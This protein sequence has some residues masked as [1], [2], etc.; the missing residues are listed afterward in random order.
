[1]MVTKLCREV[2]ENMSDILEGVAREALFDHLAG[3]ERCRDARH[4]AEQS[5][6][7]VRD[8]ALDYRFPVGL[9]ARLLASLPEEQEQTPERAEA[10]HEQAEAEHEQAE[11]EQTQSP[12]VALLARPE[13]SDAGLAVAL[14]RALPGA[15][16]Q[17]RGVSKG[18]ELPASRRA[19]LRSSP[20]RAAALAALTVLIVVVLR[21]VWFH[22][23]EG[24]PPRGND[25]WQGQVLALQRAFGSPSGLS[26]CT[27][28]GAC[29]PLAEGQEI[30]AGARLETDGLTRALLK[31]ADGST[32]ALDRATRLDLTASGQR[33]ARLVQGN[34]VAEIRERAEPAGTASAVIDT[35][36][37]RAEVQGTKFSLLADR[38]QA[39]VEVSRGVVRLIDAQERS[40]SV[41][42]GEAGQIAGPSE[43][44]LESALDL[45]RS[46]A[47]SSSAFEPSDP[48]GSSG[49]L[50]SLSAKRPSD[51]QELS[52]AV[53]LTEHDVKVQIV[54][55]IAR[56]E[57]EEVFSN[58]TD[59]VLEGI[60]RFPLPPGAQ[61]ERLALDVDGKLVD[62]AYVDRERAAAIWRGAIVNAGGKKA[63]AE[64]IIWVPGPW[65]DPALLEWQRGNRFELRIYPIPRR[66]SRRVLI[67]YTER[68]ASTEGHRQYVYPL[69]QD[70]AAS[71]RIERFTLDVQVRGHD[72]ARGVQA[73]GYALKTLSAAPG[74]ARLA[75]A[76][77]SFAPSGDLVLDYQLANAAAPLRAWA[78]Q[79]PGEQPYV[80]LLLR[81]ELPRRAEYQPRDYVLV[82]DSSRS[83]IGENYRRALAVVERTIREM[84]RNDR[85]S[86]LACDSECQSW[87]GGYQTP[88]DAAADVAGRFLRGIEPEGAS[89][90]AFAVER[91][92]ALGERNSSRAL[93]LVYLGDGTPTVGPIHPAL[94]RHAVNDVLPRGASLSAVAI[95]SDADRSSLQ[96]LTE[97]AGGVTVAFSPG[98]SAEDVAY[99]LL[100][101]SYGHTLKNARLTLPE[102]LVAVA[103]ERLGSIAAGAEELVV[104]RLTRPMAT[105]RSLEGQVVEG[106][107][108]LR[109]EL[110]GEPFEQSYPLRITPSS[111]EGNAFV[112]RLYA[113]VA[114]AELDES[115][116][117]SARR[118]SIE[119]STRFNVAS[120]YTS[121]LVL[122]SPAMFKAFGLDNRRQAPEWSGTLDSQESETWGGQAELA[123]QAPGA[124]SGFADKLD[125][126]S[127]K[128]SKAALSGQTWADDLGAAD[129][130]SEGQGVVSGASG[131]S[132]GG[133]GRGAGA[134]QLARNRSPSAAPPAA[135]PTAR[136]SLPPSTTGGDPDTDFGDEGPLP[137]PMQPHFEALRERPRDLP[138][139]RL[140]PMRR[141]YDRVGSIDA[142]PRLLDIAAPGHLAQLEARASAEQL[143][144]GALKEL[145]VADFLAGDLERAADAAERWSEKDPLDPDALTARADLAAQRGQ[146]ELAIRILG[147]VVDVRPGDYKAQW[148]L[149]RLHR[150]AGDP[151][152]G[153]RHSLAVAQLMLRD[154]KLVAEA[155]R[156]ARDVGQS[157][158]LQDL[159]SALTAQVREQVS[160]LEARAQPSAELSGDLRVQASW[161]GAEHDLDLVLLHPHG[162]RVSW[163]GAPTR[164]VISATDVL[165]VHREG[166]GLRGADPGE[167]ALEIVR[168]SPATG[169]VRGSV[170]LSVGKTERTIPFVLEGARARLATAE[171]RL[172]SRLVPLEG[173]TLGAE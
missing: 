107:A 1:M 119:L 141:V 11:A 41:R 111:S 69:P 63:P 52:G 25:A 129:E 89:D 84:D 32:L 5:L 143:S 122:E 158:W 95:G 139:R 65:R 37:G 27:P 161:Q 45:G 76:A 17:G 155:L 28:D 12:A 173:W 62:G 66:S 50:G 113:S 101:A 24:G 44:R 79:P 142:P 13:H 153:C 75:F 106:E 80:A 85:V 72:E 60:Y 21:V 46:L 90:L 162:Y 57:V 96:V 105:G 88:G 87:P 133:S 110:A 130:E 167:Y 146:R 3:C 64:E 26:R 148:R 120:R 172:H 42:A 70:P 163:L 132:L 115:M 97:A 128:K 22:E 39:R 114:I 91:A 140:I 53:Q 134:A 164:A 15:A 151:A 8:A 14:Q 152:R 33:R 103:P 112:P 4:D 10:E 166:L 124:A 40:V 51:Q 86:V 150:W 35:A 137:E 170:Q 104:A 171:I 127:E 30:P 138:A 83:M 136:R 6:S 147:S 77:E 159:T 68:I 73:H 67:A 61:I 59:E 34:L 102:G 31:L 156:C 92:V 116:D 16:R 55:S 169:P 93:R 81:P 144:R 117:E 145:Y 149:A 36:A 98:Q 165:S 29:Q 160:R 135:L 123:N 131:G 23:P 118:R 58:Q 54:D 20:L 154:A 157:G 82:V 74:V 126:Q 109:G 19:R 48:A 99:A 94:L 125:Q 56:T 38:D 43:P 100:G 9:E 108:V 2:D 7:Q 18:I 47:W 78:Y 49:A 168:S 71:T 121:L